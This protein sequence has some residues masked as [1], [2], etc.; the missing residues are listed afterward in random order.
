MSEDVKGVYDKCFL[1][2]LD[3]TTTEEQFKKLFFGSVGDALAFVN[4]KRM[5]KS[6][7]DSF[8]PSIDIEVMASVQRNLEE[9]GIL[10]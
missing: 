4:S 10:F 6:T 1:A 2:C 9:R 8:I 3:A 5:Q 7:I